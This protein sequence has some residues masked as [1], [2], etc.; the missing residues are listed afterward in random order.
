M[1]Q[2]FKVGLI[3]CGTVGRGVAEI[4]RAEAG[5]IANKTGVRLEL[6]RVADIDPD[7]PRQAGVPDK[8]VTTEASDVI[9][10]RRIAAVIELVGGTNVARDFVLRALRAGKDVVTANKPCWQSMAR[11]ST[12]RRG[13]TSSVSRSRPVAG[14]ASR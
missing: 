11:R 14:A 7:R 6:A 9:E 4:L 3:G 8:L 2:A 10:D 1:A 13:R 12:G 5:E